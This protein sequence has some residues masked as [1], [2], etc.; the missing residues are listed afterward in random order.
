MHITIVGGGFGGVKA[1]LLLSKDARNH[2]TLLTD[3]P[4]FQN[5]P[6][7]YQTATGKTH[8]QTWIP[9]GTIFAGKKNVEVIIDPIVSINKPKQYIVGASGTQYDYKTLVIALGSVT[10]Y[11][12]IKGLDQY[13][14]GIKSYDEVR[15]L[16][17]RIHQELQSKSTQEKHYV[18]IGAGP[19]GVE[20][21]S[22]LRDYIDEIAA[23]YGSRH[24][25]S[26]DVVEAVPRV[27]PKMPERVSKQVAARLTSLG[28]N[29]MTGVAVK[30]QTPTTLKLNKGSIVSSTVVW[31]SGV[32]NH[33]FFKAN[34]TA[35]QFAPNGR[36]VV[37]DHMKSSAHI[38]V[39]GDNA[40]TPFGG[41]A[42]TALYD[43]KF[44]ATNIHRH[45]NGLPLKKYKPVMPPVVVPVGRRW[46]V[47]SW[48]K[49]IVTGWLGYAIHRAANLI[50]YT[51]ILPLSKA[52][53][54]WLQQS[55]PEE[56]YFDD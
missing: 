25:Y 44:I 30:E 55:A 27:L 18:V 22:Y 32:A 24:H 46:A 14:Y 56:D 51:D 50:G 42:Q 47:V 19:T 34:D 23:R 39:I 12:G 9:L 2:I 11:F 5:Y 31:T 4:D 33:P 38:Y 40:F 37:D 54:I 20:L 43:A 15:S 41:L 28:V 17:D 21:S 53:P 52:L 7:L 45:Q 8:S 36:V 49:I 29:V 26:I 16:K 3:K 13:A 6:T 1:A 35:F 48:K 10:T